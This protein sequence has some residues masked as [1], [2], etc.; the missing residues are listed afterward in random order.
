MQVCSCLCWHYITFSTTCVENK[1][2]YSTSWCWCVL[3]LNVCANSLQAYKRKR[4][5]AQFANNKLLQTFNFEQ[6]SCE[7]TVKTWPVSENYKEVIRYINFTYPNKAFAGM[8]FVQS[9]WRD[10]FYDWDEV[11]SISLDT[12]K[13]FLLQR[14]FFLERRKEGWKEV[15]VS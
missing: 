3:D 13:S 2:V 12:L 10:R 9:Y 1:L 7:R 15:L 4:V 14:Y 8:S 5:D 11:F 6:F